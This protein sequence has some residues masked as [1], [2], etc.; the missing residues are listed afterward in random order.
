MT[1]PTCAPAIIAFT[2]PLRLV[3]R[4]NKDKWAPTID[5]I[6]NHTYE[7]VKLHRLSASLDIGLPKPLCMH[8]AFDGSLLLPQIERFWPIEKAVSAFNG[9]LAYILLGGI[10]FGP[11]EPPDIDQAVLYT[12]G[13]FRPVGMASSFVSQIRMGLQSKIASPLHAILLYQ[14]KHVFSA[15]IHKAYK[16]G[17]TIC[18]AIPSL[19]AEF[20]V[21]GVAAFISHDWGGSLSYLWITAEQIV[22]HLWN[23]HVVARVLQPDPAIAGRREFLNDHRTWTTSTRVEVLFQK[24][25]LSTKTY[26]LL[27]LARKA[28]NDLAHSGK[29]P[30]RVAAEAALDSVFQLIAC[31]FKPDDIDYFSGR[32]RDY[33]MLSPIERQYTPQTVTRADQGGLW[34]GPLP[35]IPGENE[36]GNKPYEELY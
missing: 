28:R 31:V 6:N 13:Y 34:M 30:K 11:V 33:K 32:L 26:E 5:D 23:T 18:S 15:D 20:L 22:E 14:P 21:H 12:T 16:E 9:I 27:S 19:S 35:P 7:Y 1:K 25:I 36:W 24:G 2:S 3:F 17:K 4:D 10:Y 29:L 8:V